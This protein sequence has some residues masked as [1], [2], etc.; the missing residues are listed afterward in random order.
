MP[1]GQEDTARSYFTRLLGILEDEEREPLRERG[2]CWLRLGAAIVHVGA[3]PDFRPQRKAHPALLVSDI[4]TLARQLQNAGH[5]VQWDVALP[6]R[7]R[8]YTA[9]PFG[10][11]LE[12]IAG[13]EGFTQR[14]D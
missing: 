2:G 5:P 4:D 7:R 13:G 8:F 10:N 14:R 1:T 3:D 12:F 9:D 11:R 6:D